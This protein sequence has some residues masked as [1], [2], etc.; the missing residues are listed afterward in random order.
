M[1]KGKNH[2]QER[3]SIGTVDYA[4]T[5][6]AANQSIQHNNTYNKY[7]HSINKWNGGLIN[8]I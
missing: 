7:P 6:V 5:R 1:A 3:Y 8:Y 2:A 4:I